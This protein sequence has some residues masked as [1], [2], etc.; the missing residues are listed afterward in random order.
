MDRNTKTN[1]YMVII[2]GL[3]LVC[4]MVI[5]T[6]SLFLG[7]RTEEKTQEQTLIGSS[8]HVSKEIASLVDVCWK[9]NR[10]GKA[11]ELDICFKINLRLQDPY[12]I[13]RELITNYLE[14]NQTHFEMPVELT[15]N[16]GSFDIRY[17][18]GNGSKVML[19]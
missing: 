16:T 11:E 3:V 19:N 5:F 8:G 18:P 6:R 13:E 14:I 1:L 2:F 12:S 7:V 4:M 17:L 10:E 9:K 15:R